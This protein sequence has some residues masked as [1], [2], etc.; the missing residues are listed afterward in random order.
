MPK[1]INTNYGKLT[2]EQVR[3]A[4]KDRVVI[5]NVSATE[6]HGPHMPL[7]TDTVL[8]MAVANGVAAAIPDEVL[9][10]P[11]IAYGFNE[12]HKDF[13]GVIWIQPET[14]IAFIT[15]VTKSL[16]HH[17]FRRILLLNSHGSN[18][19]VLD[20]AARKTVIETEIICVSASYWNLCSER[21]NAIRQSDIGGIA[22]A[23]EFEA[24]MYAHLEPEH[25]DLSKA[26]TQNLHDD[27]SQFF[28][29][30]LTT[31]GGKAMLMR[32]WSAVSPDGTMGDPVV[33]NPE[34]GREFLAAAIE[35]TTALVREIRALPILSRIDHH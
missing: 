9:V 5:L 35:E 26:A 1:S 15:D 23:C 20:L 33:A 29:L 34:T 13:P 31:G 22:H 25:V 24:A 32:W 3:D 10:M 17:G 12:H 30:D 14:L 19:P 16:A 28:N 11:P 4:D 7:D 8:G 21:I 2:W 27:K 6:D 18:H